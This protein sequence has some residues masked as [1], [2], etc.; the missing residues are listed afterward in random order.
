MGD[1]NGRS[2][3]W[4][5]PRQ[6]DLAQNSKAPEC[7]RALLSFPASWI[8]G[9]FRAAEDLALVQCMRLQP[10]LDISGTI[11]NLPAELDISRPLTVGT[12]SA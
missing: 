11:A 2:V 10:C 6:G 4:R 8:Y 3:A 12:Q 7:S 1:R 9:V 5:H